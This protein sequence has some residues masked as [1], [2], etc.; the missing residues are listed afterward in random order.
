MDFFSGRS[1]GRSGKRF[2]GLV[3]IDRSATGGTICGGG[4]L[5]LF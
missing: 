1:D 4:E 2:G 5:V 3:F